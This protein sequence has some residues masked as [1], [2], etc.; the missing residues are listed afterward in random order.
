M[1]VCVVTEPRSSAVPN[2]KPALNL[3]IELNVDGELNVA[4]PLDE[5]TRFIKVPSGDVI[6]VAAV[7]VTHC[8]SPVVPLSDMVATPDAGY[9]PLLATSCLA[10]TTPP[11]IAET[12]ILPDV[13]LMPSAVSRLLYPSRSA[14]M[15]VFMIIL[16]CPKGL[17]PSKSVVLMAICLC[18]FVYIAVAGQPILLS[19]DFC[20]RQFLLSLL[21]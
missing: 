13:T 12:S 14:F 8:M 18:F 3:E 17:V 1:T 5:P 19:C 20:F 9:C 15:F 7:R 21:N 4:A 6:E 10:F 2:D 11:G 16:D